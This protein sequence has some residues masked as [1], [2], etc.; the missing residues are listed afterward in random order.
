MK[1]WHDVVGKKI[2]VSTDETTNENRYVTNMIIG[3][4][5]KNTPGKLYLLN[6]EE[7]DKAN[8][9]TISEFFDQSMFL[10]WHSLWIH[11]D[12]L[13]FVTNA[14][15]YMIKAAN[16]LKVLYSKM[17]HVACLAHAH[18]IVT[19][20]ICG[21]F[22]NVDELVSNVKSIFESTITLR[23]LIQKPLVFLYLWCL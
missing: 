18:H 14:A 21:K 15:P 11:D 7:L 20:R 2:F 3:I 23:F 8:Y 16:T 5:D 6:S 12:V 17:V 9:C 4:L 19:D 13:L 1:W 22:S 10:L